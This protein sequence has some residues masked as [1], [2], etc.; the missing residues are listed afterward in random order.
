MTWVF[1]LPVAPLP[2]CDLPLP[3]AVLGLSLASSHPDVTSGHRQWLPSE[4]YVALIV[5]VVLMNLW[6]P[7]GLQWLCLGIPL[8]ALMDQSGR[9]Y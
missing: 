7:V 9:D 5:P 8:I 4:R 2:Y 3:L 1:G 6:L